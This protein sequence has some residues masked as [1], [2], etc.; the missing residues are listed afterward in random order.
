MPAKRPERGLQ[1]EY[2]EAERE[3]G[4]APTE[5]KLYTHVESNDDRSTLI[6][7]ADRIDGL[8]SL[9][10]GLKDVNAT[11]ITSQLLVASPPVGDIPSVVL[12]LSEDD[13][14]TKDIA[15]VGFKNYEI[16]YRF[17]GSNWVEQGRILR[18]QAADPD[19]MNF[20]VAHH[21]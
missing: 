15:I 18:A 8:D 5:D 11:I 7:H 9:V 1:S 16:Y 4:I 14:E 12:D 17:D 6:D 21:P 10:T 2:T 19:T 13:S 20:T 3:A